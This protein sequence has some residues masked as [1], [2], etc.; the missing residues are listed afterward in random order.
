MWMS[1]QASRSGKRTKSPVGLSCLPWRVWYSFL[2]LVSRLFLFSV[3]QT[4]L[5]E[6]SAYT[7]PDPA[8]LF[9][10]RLVVKLCF[11]FCSTLPFLSLPFFFPSD[12]PSKIFQLL[13]F[14]AGSGWL[15]PFLS[16]LSIL[17]NNDQ[18]QPVLACVFL[19]AFAS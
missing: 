17:D 16:A 10:S 6:P 7:M 15:S 14:A 13:C 1:A 2:F 18:M 8:C 5:T 19:L 12:L 3:S 4:D 11:W 9:L